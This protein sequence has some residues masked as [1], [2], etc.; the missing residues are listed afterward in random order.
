MAKERLCTKCKFNNN[1]WCEKLKTNKNL[2]L[3]TECVFREIDAEL[4]L[5]EVKND[6]TIALEN[7]IKQKE[8]EL[9]IHNNTFNKGV[10]EGLKI[11]L[12]IMKN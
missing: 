3:L 11:A 4:N 6:K 7:C 10:I 12:L 1:G 2:K 9:K 5:E 8:L